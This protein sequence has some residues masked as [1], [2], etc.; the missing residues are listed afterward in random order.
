MFAIVMVRAFLEADT[1]NEAYTFMAAWA[2]SL[3]GTEIRLEGYPEG[4]VDSLKSVDTNWVNESLIC[5][6]V[7]NVRETGPVVEALDELSG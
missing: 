2:N 4:T 5:T 6:I 1:I 7:V 3:P